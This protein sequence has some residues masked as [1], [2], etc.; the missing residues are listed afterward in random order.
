M[1]NKKLIGLLV[2]ATLG[3]SACGH[4]GGAEQHALGTGSTSTTGSAGGANNS[5]YSYY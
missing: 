4:G 1:M 5:Y 2:V 3:L